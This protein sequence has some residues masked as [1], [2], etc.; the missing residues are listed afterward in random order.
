MRASDIKVIWVEPNGEFEDGL[1]EAFV[2]DPQPDGRVKLIPISGYLIELGPGVDYWKTIYAV[3]VIN[4]PY[5]EKGSFFVEDSK[6]GLLHHA[7]SQSVHAIRQGYFPA[8]T[9]ANL[10][11]GLPGFE[12][13]YAVMNMNRTIQPAGQPSPR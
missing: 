6:G 4:P 7:I 11:P 13:E 9:L 5:L 2:A 8:S 3:V 10:P 12:L 1:L